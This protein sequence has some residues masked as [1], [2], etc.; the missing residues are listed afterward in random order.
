MTIVF[1][2]NIF[3]KR[4]QTNILQKFCKWW[5]VHENRQFFDGNHSRQWIWW[6]FQWI[7]ALTKIIVNVLTSARLPLFDEIWKRFFHCHQKESTPIGQNSLD[8]PIWWFSWQGM[9]HKMS[10]W[11]DCDWHL[12][13]LSRQNQESIIKFAN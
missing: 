9:D 1:V 12:S 5:I 13:T 4:Q 7:L 11:Q 6:H 3:Y 8:V 10:W 2:K